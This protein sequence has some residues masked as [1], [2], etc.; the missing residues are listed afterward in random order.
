MRTRCPTEKAVWVS[1]RLVV[2]VSEPV[3][4][5]LEVLLVSPA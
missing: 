4:T 1:E 5:A 2:K 3:P